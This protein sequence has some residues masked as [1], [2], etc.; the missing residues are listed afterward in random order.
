M[1]FQQNQQKRKKSQYAASICLSWGTTDPVTVARQLLPPPPPSS[2]FY[3]ECIAKTAS[4]ST[5]TVWKCTRGVSIHHIHCLTIG[6]GEACYLWVPGGFGPNV[7]LVSV[8]PSICSTVHGV[9]DFNLPLSQPFCHSQFLHS[10]QRLKTATR[11]H[12]VFMV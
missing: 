6:I 7:E 11:N 12:F 9:L 1:A 5:L 2:P 10:A 8:C 3:S 4:R